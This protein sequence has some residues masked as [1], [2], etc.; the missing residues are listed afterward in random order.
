MLLILVMILKRH[1]MVTYGRAPINKGEKEV[2]IQILMAR[3]RGILTLITRMEL[4]LIGTITMGY[5]TN[6]ESSPIASSLFQNNEGEFFMDNENEVFYTEEVKRDVE[7][8]Q[9]TDVM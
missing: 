4:P 1:Q 9:V 2:D 5:A 8:S 3:I 6:G 7:N